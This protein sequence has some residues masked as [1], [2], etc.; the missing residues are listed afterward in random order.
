[1]LRIG[2]VVWGVQDVERAVKFWT[3]A[4]DYRPRDEP[5][6][7]WVVL[8]P[9]E[10]SGVQ[11][12][13]KRVTSPQARRH[14]LDLYATD[15]AAE[16]RYQ[17]RIEGIDGI[18]DALLRQRFAAAST[19][20]AN[21]GEPANAAQLDRRAREDADLLV[22]LLRA[23]GYYDARVATRVEPGTRPLVVLAAE[24]GTLYRFAGV[25]LPGVEAAG[26]KADELRRS[27]GV[28]ANDPVDADKV[29]AGE[30]QLRAQVGREGFPFVEVSEPA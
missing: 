2:S 28:A 23:A 5:D 10:G 22:S 21:D 13:L 9:R 16:A 15:A 30:A 24:P 14:H 27:F 6:A 12:A 29:A 17:W 8:V 25:R 1:M 18:G 26:D 4:L 11:L 7:N 3:Q 20:D 19:L